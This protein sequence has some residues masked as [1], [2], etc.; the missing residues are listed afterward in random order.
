MKY[1][2]IC[3][4]CG[5][6]LLLEKADTTALCKVCRKRHEKWKKENE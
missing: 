5:K 3:V 4:F 1:S 2:M 6:K